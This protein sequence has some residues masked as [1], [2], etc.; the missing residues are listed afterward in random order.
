MSAAFAITSQRGSVEVDAR[1]PA[2]VDFAVVNTS[3]RALEGQGRI[4]VDGGA[5]SEWFTIEGERTRAFAAGAV[6]RYSVRIA[7]P[8]TVPPGGYRFRLLVVALESPDDLFGDSAWIA[9]EVDRPLPAP[10]AGVPPAPPAP[11]QVPPQPPAPPAPPAPLAPGRVPPQQP[12]PG[13]GMAPAPYARPSRK[14]FRKSSKR[15]VPRS[16]A[17]LVAEEIRGLV[18]GTVLFN[19]PERMSVGVRERVEVRIAIGPPT[20]GL[21]QGLKGHGPP[22]TEP[23]QVGTFM[24]ARLSGG[25]FDVRALSSEEQV[26]VD[27]RPTQWE[28]DVTALQHGT[29][30]LSLAVSVRLTIRDAGEKAMDYPVFDRSIKVSVNPVYAARTFVKAYWQWIVGTIVGSGVIGW[31]W[32]SWIHH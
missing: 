8:S 25:H 1:R 7:L 15:D 23:L 5:R 12:A 9:L 19:P 31:L 10:P 29:Q 30:V 2:V 13:P 24:K 16:V 11:A 17:R 32:Q 20:P 14:K 27:G 28:W 3:G 26:V 4:H 6:E 18:S 21:L 22:Q